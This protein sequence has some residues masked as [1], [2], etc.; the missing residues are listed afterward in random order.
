MR[1]IP[2]TQGKV[3]LVDDADYERLSRHRWHVQGGHSPDNEL[4]YAR[5]GRRLAD[6]STTKVWMH[7]EIMGLVAGD[8][9]EVDHMDGDG[10]NNQRRNL[11]VGT[12][13]QN[14]LNMY[15]HRVGRLSGT[16]LCRDH[17]RT[18]PWNA[19]IKV[20]GQTINLGYYATEEAAHTAFMV[21]L[22]VRDGVNEAFD[23]YFNSRCSGKGV[24]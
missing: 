6:G 13:S 15:K 9:L 18:K 10:L 4:W 24:L 20:A 7:R 5:R 8:G 12:K 16:K 19:G 2:L 21:A 14:M 22:A 23:S 17:P 1:T 3:A 11:R